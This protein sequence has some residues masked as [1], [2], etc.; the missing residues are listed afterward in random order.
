MTTPFKPV[1]PGGKL[2]ARALNRLQ[3]TAERSAATTADAGGGLEVVRS[4]D[5]VHFRLSALP[6]LLVKVTGRVMAS[7]GGTAPNSYYSGQQVMTDKGATGA[8]DLLTGLAFTADAYPL[9]EANGNAGVPTGT[10]VRAFP[11]EGLDHYTFTFGCKGGTGSLTVREQPNGPAVTIVDTLTFF[12]LDATG[13]GEWLVSTPSAGEARVSMATAGTGRAG[14]VVRNL[15]QT[16]ALG[17]GCKSADALYA[18]YRFSPTV[19]YELSGHP[20]DPQHEVV[21]RGTSGFFNDTGLH[22]LGDSRVYV[23][24]CEVASEPIARSQFT[25][26]QTSGQH[27]LALVESPGCNIAFFCGNT[28]DDGYLEFRANALSTFDWASFTTGQWMTL[29]LGKPSNGATGTNDRSATLNVGRQSGFDGVFFGHV[30][31][32]QYHAYLGGGSNVQPFPGATSY[33]D[34]WNFFRCVGGIVIDGGF[35]DYVQAILG[36]PPINAAAAGGGVWAVGVNAHPWFGTSGPTAAAGTGFPQVPLI[37][38]GGTPTGT[39]APRPGYAPVVFDG[40]NDVPWFWDGAAWKAPV[41]TAAGSGPAVVTVGPATKVATVE[42]AT[43][44]GATASTAGA[45]GVPSA[46]AAGDHVKFWRGDGTWA[47]AGTGGGGGTV[48]SVALTMPT[49]VFDVSGSPVTSAG[50]L[51]VTFDTQSANQVFAGPTSGG[52]AAPAFRA[53][54]LDDLP[55]LGVTG[56]GMTMRG[57][58]DSGPKKITV[59]GGRVTAIDTLG[60]VNCQ[61]VLADVTVTT[62]INTSTCEVTTT[63]TKTFKVFHDGLWNSSDC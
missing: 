53:V 9:V 59:T 58:G 13:A 61:K 62:S 52:A 14:I 10:I 5:G 54:V 41:A 39:P 28:V 37:S 49:S 21:L 55:S 33:P 63:V 2:S 42:V 57:T 44:V 32:N 3:D 8:S 48:T 26:H 7:T 46:P 51:A 35:I 47:E 30:A 18:D 4:A 56:T 45:R 19:E 29:Y 38:S 60:D 11:G 34:T 40:A 43:M 17:M 24:Y 22:V 23:G 6:Y 25:I 27:T 20:F 12:S 1:R 31:C 50:T 15:H 16:Q 36:D